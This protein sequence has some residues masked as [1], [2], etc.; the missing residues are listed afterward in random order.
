M[1]FQYGREY[2]WMMNVFSVVIAYSITCPII[3]PFGEPFLGH[4]QGCAP[5]GREE[6]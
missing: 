6:G 3:V 4:P 5:S 1:D 2:A